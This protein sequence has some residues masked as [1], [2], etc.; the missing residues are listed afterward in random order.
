MCISDRQ[1]HLNGQLE[2]KLMNINNRVREK[3]GKLLM[4]STGDPMSNFVTGVGGFM[5]FFL[6]AEKFA[7]KLM[8]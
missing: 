6:V 2:L 1:S 8:T 5:C 3:H 7:E 4:T